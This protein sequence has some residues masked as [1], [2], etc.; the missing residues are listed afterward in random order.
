MLFGMSRLRYGA[1]CA[2]V[3]AAYGTLSPSTALSETDDGGWEQIDFDL[4]EVVQIDHMRPGQQEPVDVRPACAL[5][6][7]YSYF[8]REGSDPSKLV[9]FF[10]G[11]GACF[12]AETCD[13]SPLFSDPPEP[14]RLTYTPIIDETVDSL[15]AL[16]DDDDIPAAGILDLGDPENPYADH[17]II[18]I[19]YC[20]GDVHWGS[21]VVD[22]TDRSDPTD[23]SILTK[24]DVIN[25]HHRGADNV[26]ATLDSVR[27]SLGE[28]KISELVVTG[29]SAGSYG[30]TVAYPY[31]REMF[32]DA[33]YSDAK[34]QGIFDAGAGV[35]TDYFV[36]TAL[37]G[38]GVWNFPP[39]L[40]GWV[41][42]NASLFDL[43]ADKLYGALKKK[44]IR[45]Y[46]RDRFAEVTDAWDF[47]QT[48]FLQIMRDQAVI[49]QI[50]RG[51]IP[52]PAGFFETLFQPQPET[53]CDWTEAVRK[54]L[55][56]VTRKQRNA[57]YYLSAGT[58]HTIMS[59]NGSRLRT[60]FWLND[61]YTEDSARRGV[62]F[63]QWHD[64][65]RNDP[66][67]SYLPWF[68]SGDR[69]DNLSCAPHCLPADDPNV[70]EL[71]IDPA[72]PLSC[73]SQA[74]SH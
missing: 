29:V 66:T 50:K 14:E 38:D 34:A 61:F 15:N 6:Q 21:K 20:T 62:E 42:L 74:L 19:P 44:V 37:E 51:E 7:R 70:L 72:L 32:R 31:I 30:A 18:F 45:Y 39:Y 49:D 65:M 68:G 5:G 43:P 52:P 16:T 60:G 10:D 64:A 8:R 3:A 17:T 46:R 56:R 2:L 58:E 13:P 33:L 48:Q 73:L 1:Y 71:G 55:W 47:V 59:G 57:R 63:V 54:Y 27:T 11:G 36:D 67:G 4:G 25:I 53:F 22:Y 35:I 41:G 24:A 26:L 69:W 9:F 28:Q 23:V 40:P 12:S